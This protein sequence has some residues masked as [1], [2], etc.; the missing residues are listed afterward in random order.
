MCTTGT[1]KPIFG[2]VSVLLTEL[3]SFYR[4]EHILHS[5]SEAAGRLLWRKTRKKKV[6]SFSAA[7]WC[8]FRPENSFTVW[9]HRTHSDFF[10]VSSTIK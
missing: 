3:N 10:I 9:S 1:L 6:A 5:A 4:L 8:H 2:T 7:F